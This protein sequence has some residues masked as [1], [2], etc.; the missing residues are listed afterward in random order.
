MDLFLFPNAYIDVATIGDICKY[1]GGSLFR[2]NY[3]QADVDGERFLED[4][5]MEVNEFTCLFVLLPRRSVL[6]SH[7]LS[8]GACA[9][10]RACVP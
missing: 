5:A 1:T 7:V 9:C 2:Y 6:L 4:L 3:F 10:T 8:A